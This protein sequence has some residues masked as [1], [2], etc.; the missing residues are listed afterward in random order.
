MSREELDYL[1]KQP[2][3]HAIKDYTDLERQQITQIAQE[4]RGNPL[5]NQYELEKAALTAKIGAEFADKVLLVQN[6][7]TEVAENTRQQLLE[8]ESIRHGAPVPVSPRDNHVIHLNVLQQVISGLAK[9]A[10]GNVDAW[11]VMEQLAAH[12][13]DHLK[14]GEASNLKSQMAPYRL[15][16]TKLASTLIKL[17]QTRPGFPGGAPAPAGTPPTPGT[18]TDTEAQAI[19]SGPPPTVPMTPVHEAIS[20]SYKDLELSVRKQV[21]AKL[22]MTLDESDSEGPPAPPPTP[23]APSSA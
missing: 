16:L 14:A 19:A 18:P 11:H 6:D 5:Y 3:A 9:N 4:A 12:A 22:G 15:F 10:V 8:N 13:S 23:P 2:A 1:A 21:I 20:I 7:P 17:H